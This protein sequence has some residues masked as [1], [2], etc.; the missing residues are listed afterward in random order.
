VSCNG[1]RAKQGII[2]HLARENTHPVV[3]IAVI[4]VAS[5]DLNTTAGCGCFVGSSFP[6]QGFIMIL[7]LQSELPGR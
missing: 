2:A 1:D 7:M 4:A 3:V 6:K 5:L